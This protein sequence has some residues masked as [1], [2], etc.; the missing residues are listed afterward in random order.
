MPLF[1]RPTLRSSSSLGVHQIHEPIDEELLV[2]DR[3][4]FFHPTKP[5]EILDGKFKT[6]VKLGFGGGS[7]VWLAENL[8]HKK[9][10]K[11]SG[12]RY[13]RRGEMAKLKLIQ[14]ADK[15]HEGRSYIRLPIGHFDLHGP[16]GIH[17]CIV[18]E[19]MRETLLQFQTRLPRERLNIPLFKL[20]IYVLLQAL[21]YLHT[22][23]HL[24]HTDLKDDN[25]M[26]TIEDN[27][28][29]QDF[30]KIQ[31]KQVQVKHIRSEDGVEIYLADG[32]F[33]PLRGSRMMPKLSDFNASFP[34]LSGKDAHASPIQAHRYRAPE[35]LLGC[36]WSY[37]VDIWNLGLLMWDL[38]ENT[39]LFGR[40]AGEDSEYD[41]HVHLARMVS[42]LGPPPEKLICRERMYRNAEISLP[43][44]NSRGERF[45]NMNKYWGGPFFTDDNQ[46]YRTELIKEGRELSDTVTELAGQEKEVFIDFARNMLQWLPEDRPTAQDLLQHAFFDSLYK[47]RD[48]YL[49][50]QK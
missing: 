41:A 43:V 19:P 1:L 36:P 5:G 3:L 11:P 23:C 46:I 29:L 31:R 38:L 7:T 6:I 15:S 32:D 12:L 40:P 25:I 35:V 20:Y 16:L 49:Q 21:D 30:V 10:W 26:V 13:M 48:S 37:S 8:E 50:R 2:G 18:Y 28:L 24:I 14:D 44:Y 33:G 17:A 45:T 42:M 22:K 39:S 47:D 27:K 4:K 9:W 34:G